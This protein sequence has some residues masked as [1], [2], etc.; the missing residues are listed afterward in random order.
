MHWTEFTK[1][2]VSLLV[3]INPIGTLPTFISLTKHMPA[4]K[5]KRTAVV[6]AVSTMMVLAASF[7][8]GNAILA[9]F[10]IGIFSFRIAGGILILLMSLDMMHGH[11]NTS[12]AD[13]KKECLAVVPIAIPLLA[14]PGAISA[15]IIYANTANHFYQFAFMA[16]VSLLSGLA[17]WM[18]LVASEPIE[19]ILG[20]TGEDIATRVMGMVLGAVAIEY[21]SGG[22]GHLFPAL[23]G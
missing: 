10:G 17:V 18:S 4:S 12:T 6:A 1:L 11:K 22:I 19:R 13:A 8:M 21:I 9:F 2:L 5:K 7:A 20:E 23:L 3:I 16:I 15:S 14:G